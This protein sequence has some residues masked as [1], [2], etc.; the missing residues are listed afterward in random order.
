M[1]KYLSAL[2]KEEKHAKWS[3]CSEKKK[4]LQTN[5]KKTNNPV[6]FTFIGRWSF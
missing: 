2:E 1:K 3:L 5:E 4:Q 6:V